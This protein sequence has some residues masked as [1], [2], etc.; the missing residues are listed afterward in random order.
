[1]VWNFRDVI[2][3]FCD[4][5]LSLAQDLLKKAQKAE[6]DEQDIKPLTVCFWSDLMANP[7]VMY[8]LFAATPGKLNYDSDKVKVM[9]TKDGMI[10]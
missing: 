10:K 9:G 7:S 6:K 4:V 3:N 8:G 1:M 5:M 2:W